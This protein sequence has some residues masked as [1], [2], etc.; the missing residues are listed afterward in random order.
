M[1]MSPS[2]VSAIGFES[3]PVLSPSVGSCASPVA[4]PEV[5]SATE[6]PLPAVLPEVLELLQAVSESA[7]AAASIIAI[8]FFM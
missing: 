2:S 4:A 6:L 7:I 5:P 3:N 8:N 1:S